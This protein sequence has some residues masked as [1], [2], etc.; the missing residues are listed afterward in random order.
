MH[1]YMQHTLPVRM[2][3]TFTQAQTPPSLYSPPL[4]IPFIRLFTD[5]HPDAIMVHSKMTGG[6]TGS[7]KHRQNDSDVSSQKDQVCH[8]QYER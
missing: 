8:G 4:S 3:G 7:G 1:T 2:K 6:Q 5:Q